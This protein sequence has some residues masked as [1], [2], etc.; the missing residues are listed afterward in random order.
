MGESL[1]SRS[2]DFSFSDLLGACRQKMI[3]PNFTEENFP[4]EPV[5]PDENKWEPY[6]YGFNSWV[7]GEDALAIAQKSGYRLCGPRRA[8]EYIANGRQNNQLKNPIIITAQWKNI[9]DLMV[10]VFNSGNGE[11]VINVI[12]LSYHFP[13]NFKW[14]VLR[15]K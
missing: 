2:D 12:S 3:N 10:P 8:M 6:E 4:S 15:K 11:R 9:N 14:L 13:P 5:L 7:Q 1:L